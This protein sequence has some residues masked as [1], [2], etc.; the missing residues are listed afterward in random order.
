MQVAN[1]ERDEQIRELRAEKLSYARIAVQVGLTESGIQKACQRLGLAR[2][3]PSAVKRKEKPLRP[4]DDDF[5]P[6]RKTGSIMSEHERTAVLLS[7]VTA[8]CAHCEAWEMTASVL[9]TR[10]AFALHRATC[11]AGS[12][13]GRGLVSFWRGHSSR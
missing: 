4:D 10:E 11:S 3:S 7:T 1:H 6:G 13:P 2:V 9:E 8:R 12:V 5:V